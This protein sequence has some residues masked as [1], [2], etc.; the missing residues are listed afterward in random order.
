M[1][2]RILFSSLA[3]LAMS[4]NT[5]FS[6]TWVEKMQDPNVNF[7]DVQQAFNDYYKDYES[8]FKQNEKLKA[9]GRAKLPATPTPF[10]PNKGGVSTTATPV[11][12]ALEKD[13]PFSLLVQLLFRSSGLLVFSDSRIPSHPQF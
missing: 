2:K 5:A 12:D 10:I 7:Y 3:V 13:I 1:K 9:A 8:K 11:P 6:Q 4:V